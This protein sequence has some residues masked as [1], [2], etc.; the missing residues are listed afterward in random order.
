MSSLTEFAGSIPLNYDQYLG[1]LFFEPYALDLAERLK[2]KKYQRILEL[3]SGT[4]RLT[5]YLVELTREEG[6][7]YATDLNPDMLQIARQKTDDGRI[8][9][10]IVDAHAIPYENN[11]FDAVV[12]QFGV[13]FFKDKSQ[14]FSEI[15]RVLRPGGTFLFS[16]W[17]DVQHNAA[18][19][20]SQ[21]ILNG[22]FPGDAPEFMEKGPYSF[23]DP[24]E[25][26]R[27]LEKAG[28]SG[29]EINLVA[30]MGQLTS[31]DQVALGFVDGS[32]LTGYLEERQAPKE[33]IKKRITE[34]ILNEY[35]NLQL[36]MQA[37]VCSANK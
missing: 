29:I 5:R 20:I 12:C 22:L 33:E 24:K 37:L 36:P 19:L 10:D 6:Q 15:Y 1:P 28:F 13:M 30:K 26:I 17:D 9:W 8:H 16:T 23:Y 25:I 31:P 7:L 3:A 21:K 18:S 27:L 2:G 34:A 35:T 4:G 14:A 11:F 32:P